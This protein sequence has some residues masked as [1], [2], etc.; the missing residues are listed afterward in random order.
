MVWDE[1]PVILVR[2]VHREALI[3]G[4]RT[5]QKNKSLANEVSFPR[6]PSPAA[7][8]D[9]NETLGATAS[10]WAP[11]HLGTWNLKSETTLVY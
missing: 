6:L 3:L 10:L 9:K 11:P 8:G 7:R 4:V 2:R 5:P 1:R